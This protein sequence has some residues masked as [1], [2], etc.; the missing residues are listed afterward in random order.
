[1]TSKL[2]WVR[3]FIK[4]KNTEN[5]PLIIFPHAGSGASAYRFLAKTLS[6]HFSVYI[7]QYPGRQ[8]RVAEPCVSSLPELGEQAAHAW[9]TEKP[10]LRSQPVR[11]F[12]HSMG[13][14]VAFECARVLEQENVKVVQ[15]I[16]TGA[17]APHKISELPNHPE[18]DETVL[19]R[20]QMLGGTDSL[21]VSNPDMLKLV[22]PT[23]KADYKAFDTYDCD[24]HTRIQSDFLIMG[25]TEDPFVPRDALHHWSAH[26]TGRCDIYAVPGQHF[27][28]PDNT[29]YV[30]QLIIEHTPTTV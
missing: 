11:V 21:I 28:L 1:M 27:F 14:A 13:A 6:Q 7:M 12:G 30:T 4:P 8:D 26:T 23:I 15:L 22:L 17:H 20:L 29:E 3:Q 19:E 2:G 18:D 9:L 16:S 5:P 24:V 10:Q 25:G